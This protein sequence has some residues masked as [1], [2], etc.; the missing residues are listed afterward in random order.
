MSSLSRSL[1]PFAISVLVLLAGCVEYRV[2]VRNEN[3]ATEQTD[4]VHSF[5]WGAHMCPE[6][7]TAECGQRSIDSVIIGRN[8]GY[9]LI[10][11][12]TLGIWAPLEVT[13][14]CSAG[15][16]TPAPRE[17]PPGGRRP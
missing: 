3:V 11:V 12:F 13:Y 6:R 8:F 16:G 14:R 2:G 15:P 9:D 5:F 1:E 17:P 7:L 4:T 10:S